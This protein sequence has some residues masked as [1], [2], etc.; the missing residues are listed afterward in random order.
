MA[1]H[2]PRLDLM[3][4][5]SCNLSCAGCISLSDRPRDGVAAFVD[6]EHWVKDWSPVITP[7]VITLFGGEPCLHPRLLEICDLVRQHWPDT[8]I[9]LITNG[10]LL[11]NFNSSAW[12][13]YAP[14]EIQVSV[15][16]KDHESLISQSIKKILLHR[17][18]WKIAMNPQTGHE[19]LSWT[20]DGIKIYKSIFKDFV[21]PFKSVNGRIE[22]WHSDPTQAH[23]ICGSPNTPVLYKGQLYKCPAVA[24]AIDLSGQNWFDYTPCNSAEQLDQFIS[25]IGQPEAVCGQCPQR[26]Q[27]VVIDHFDKNNVIVKQKIS[28]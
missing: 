21:V 25:Q 2:I 18:D 12:F 8:V 1:Q 4:A 24:N 19:Q 3:I 14:L 16:R 11:D 9:R 13:A 17:K 15:H 5:Y 7:A 10:Y 27:A 20:S 28:S 6:I 23:A 26:S 22:P